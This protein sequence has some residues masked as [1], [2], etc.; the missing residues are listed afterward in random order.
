M[1]H[2]KAYTSHEIQDEIL[3]I[4]SQQLQRAILKDINASTWYCVSADE[5][6]DASLTEQVIIRDF[7]L[8]TVLL[9]S[10]SLNIAYD[11]HKA[12]LSTD[13]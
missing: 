4:M 6:I 10:F 7:L 2:K 1:Q 8:I 13:I 11:L 5:T 12:C 3:K 9:C